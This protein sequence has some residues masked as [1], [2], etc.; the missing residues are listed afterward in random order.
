MPKILRSGAALLTVGVLACLVGFVHARVSG[1]PA[2]NARPWMY[3]LLVCFGVMFLAAF[4]MAAVG[5]YHTVLALFGWDGG[6]GI[7]RKNKSY[8]PGS[9]EPLPDGTRID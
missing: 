5:A 1:G 9:D 8:I 3:G 4:Y 2:E 7:L 6:P